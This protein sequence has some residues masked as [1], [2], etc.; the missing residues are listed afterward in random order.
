MAQ[1]SPLRRRMGEIE[2]DFGNAEKERFRN[3]NRSFSRTV[4]SCLLMLKECRYVRRLK[5]C[6]C[7][8]RHRIY[9]TSSRYLPVPASGQHGWLLQS[10]G[11]VHS[12]TVL[13]NRA[14]G[15]RLPSC[16]QYHAHAARLW[17]CRQRV[18]RFLLAMMPCF[19]SSRFGRARCSAGVT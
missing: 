13:P 12:P 8:A 9:R 16:R 1:S 4:T 17:Q 3:E 18:R 15:G 19:T 14:R 11:P 10:P 5:L 2:K 7:F 6:S